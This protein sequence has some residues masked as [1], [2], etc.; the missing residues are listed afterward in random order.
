VHVLLI[1]KTVCTVFP[2]KDKRKIV[3]SAFPSFVLNGVTLQ[4]RAGPDLRGGGRGPGHQAPHQQRAPHQTLHILF[5]VQS[6]FDTHT[7]YAMLTSRIIFFHKN[8]GCT[9]G[10]P[11]Y[12]IFTL[13]LILKCY[14]EYL[15]TNTYGL[16]LT[17]QN[18]SKWMLWLPKT[19]RNR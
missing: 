4:Y 7:T 11:L 5:L 19:L 8:A 15:Y 6:T 9:I 13:I 1:C 18:W 12:N 17:G 14:T 2:P 16:D 3:A 10:L